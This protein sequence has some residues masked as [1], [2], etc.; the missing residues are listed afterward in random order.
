MGGGQAGVR[1]KVAI[2]RQAKRGLEKRIDNDIVQKIIQT[3]DRLAQD[4]YLGKPLKGPLRGKYRLTVRRDYRVVY[5]IEEEQRLVVVE[6]IG[7]RS[8]VYR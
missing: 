1:Y 6:K 7:H 8:K 3:I 4:P 2:E 5:R